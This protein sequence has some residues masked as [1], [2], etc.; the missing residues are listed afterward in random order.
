MFK[1][2]QG[3]LHYAAYGKQ[4]ADDVIQESKST[5][6]KDLTSPASG[7]SIG[8]WIEV[9]WSEAPQKLPHTRRMLDQI[10]RCVD[11]AL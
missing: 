11:F 2:M 7:R 5:W 1:I 6:E 8:F 10:L 4:I 9:T 3:E